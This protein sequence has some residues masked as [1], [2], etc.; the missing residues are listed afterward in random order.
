MGAESFVT[1]FKFARYL[2]E[3]GEAVKPNAIERA[4]RLY[5]GEAYL[6][7]LAMCKNHNTA[8]DIVSEAFVKALLSINVQETNF[9]LWLLKVCKTTWIDM[10]RR[11]RF[12]SETSIDEYVDIQSVDDVL[13]NI[14]REEERRIITS[15]LLTFPDICRE[16]VTLFYF[17]DIPQ[18]DIAEL[19][20]MSPGSVRSLIYRGR[21][22]LAE[23]L[24]EEHYGL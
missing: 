12:V 4:Y 23:Q 7:S 21:R 8:E 10:C 16:A 24:K 9:K 17:N 19:L 11:N 22:L 2:D 5:A 3:K 20:N 14:I 13:L 18:T 6:H 15:A 1:F